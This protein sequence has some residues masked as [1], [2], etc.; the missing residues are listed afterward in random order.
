V[1][2]RVLPVRWSRVLD[3][4]ALVAMAT[5][6]KHLQDPGQLYMGNLPDDINV[7]SKVV[8]DQAV[9]GPCHLP[10][11]HFRELGAGRLG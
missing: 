6:A 4:P 5:P 1:G 10:P 8:V 3:A 11:R 2:G 7:H 9:S